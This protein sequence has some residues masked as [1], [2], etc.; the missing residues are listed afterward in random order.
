MYYF[1][2]GWKHIVLSIKCHSPL[3]NIVRN[4]GIPQWTDKSEKV[5]K[6]SVKAKQKQLISFAEGELL[7]TEGEATSSK[8][9]VV[10]WS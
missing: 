1:T 7:G 2:L 10:C 8:G 5:S 3:L 4:T 6:I 9:C